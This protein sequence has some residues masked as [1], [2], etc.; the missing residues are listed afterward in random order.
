MKIPDQA[1]RVFKG[2]I[3]DVYQWE[4]EMFDGSTATFEMLQRPGTV[5]VIAIKDNLIWYADE[6]QPSK[7]KFL[8]FFGGRIEAGEAPEAAAKRELL[9]EA[10]M[11]SNDWE[12]FLTKDSFGKIYWLNYLFIARNCTNH[13]EQ[14]LDSGEKIRVVSCTFEEFIQK[15]LNQEIN[16]FPHVTIA[17][18]N[19]QYREPGKLEEFKKKLGLV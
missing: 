5:E 8:S 16:T 4:Q 12:L 13:R 6:E 17:I 1:K 7:G 11:A 18:M 9:E 2:K 14:T 15:I 10:G 19:Y 3:F